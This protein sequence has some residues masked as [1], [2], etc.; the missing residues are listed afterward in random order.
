MNETK[1]EILKCISGGEWWTTTQVAHW[2]G[3]KL[4][5]VSELMRRYRGQGLVT[6]ERNYHVPHGYLY[7][8]TTVGIERLEYFNI[9][10]TVPE[11]CELSDS[12]ITLASSTLADKIGLVGEKNNLFQKWVNSQ[13]EVKDDGN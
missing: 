7:K 1:T 4:T 10:K 5:N 9:E 6:R 2:C 12:T 3:L 13:L 8:I 11:P